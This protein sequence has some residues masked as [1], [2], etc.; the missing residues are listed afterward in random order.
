MPRTTTVKGQEVVDPDNASTVIAY[1][2]GQL[3]SA[4]REGFK[5]HDA[6]LDSLTS[7]FVTKDEFVALDKRVTDNKKELDLHRSK[8]WIWKTASA[9]A[10]AALALLIAYSVTGRAG[11]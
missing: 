9:A 10:G 8:D 6:K 11:A 3:E 2:V 5:A 7:N 4:V 1:R